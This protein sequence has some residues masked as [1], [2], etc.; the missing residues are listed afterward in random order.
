VDSAIARTV[1]VFPQVEGLR[2][3]VEQWLVSQGVSEVLDEYTKGL[4]GLDDLKIEFLAEALLR[5]TQFFVPE[6]AEATARE[7]VSRFLAEVRSEYLKIPELG[8]QLIANRV[9]EGSARSA[10][11]FDVLAAGLD[12]VKARLPVEA[13][14]SDAGAFDSQIDEARRHLEKYEYELAEHVCIRLRQRNWDGLNARQRF[15]TLSNL[16]AA[17]IAQGR[18]AEGARLLIEAKDWQ[19]DDDKALGNEARA[20]HLLGQNDRAFELATRA[21][22][23]FPNSPL[24]LTVWLNT[25]PSSYALKDLEDAV[26]AHLAED[27]EVVSALAER[28]LM[29][30]NNLKAEALARRA[31]SIKP[32]WSFPWAL[33]GG[34]VFRSILPDAPEDYA[35]LDS[36]ADEGRLREADEACTRAI[37][38]G[39]AEK[40][41]SVQA[42][43]LLIRAEVRRSLGDR[44]AGDEDVIAAWSPQPDDPTVLREYA[45]LKLQHGEK[46]DAIEKLRAAVR[47]E[48][49]DDLRMLLALSLSSTGRRDDRA[50][51]AQIYGSLATDPAQR[52]AGFRMHAIVAALDDFATDQ[53]WVEGRA[54]LARLPVGCLADTVIAALQ[55]KLELAAGNRE[56]ASEL[57]SEALTAI[58]ENTVPE[59]LRLA[60]TVLADLGRHRDALP[61]WQRLASPRY[62]GYDTSRLIDCALRVGQHDVFLTLC[63]Q[64]RS[65]GVY[66]RQLI[67]VEAGVREHY[68]VESAINLLQDYLSRFPEDCAARLH[69][70]AI[71]LQL[72][73]PELVATD[74]ASMPLPEDVPPENWKLIV[75]VMKSGGHLSEALRFAYSVLRR[76]FSAAEAHRAYLAAMLVTGP[77]PEIPRMDV[78]GPGTAVAFKEEGTTQEEWRIIEEEFEPDPGLQEIGPDHFI[79]VHLKGKRVGETFLLAEGSVTSTRGTIT[80]ILSKYV[81]RFQECSGNWQKRFPALP[82]IQSLRVLRVGPGGS[83]EIDLTQFFASLDRIAALQQKA[84]AAYCSQ[85]IPMHLLAQALSRTEF[86]QTIRLAVDDEV[87]VRC[88][89]GSAEERAEA[90]A[91]LK[92][93]SAVV[94]D[95][96]AIA[97]LSLLGALGELE[98]F[99]VEILISELTF[100]ELRNSLAVQTSED[101]EMGFLGKEGD[102]YVLEPAAPETLRVRREFLQSIV[103][104]VRS[105]CR[106]TGCPELAAVPPDRR[107]FLVKAIGEHGAQ[108]AVLASAPRRVLWTDDFCL[109]MIARHEFGARRVWTQVVLQERTEAGAV[110]P[111]TF[112]E[113]TAKL[114]GWR[115]Y[116]TSPSTPAL[117]RAGSL[118]EWN[119]ERRPLRSALELFSDSGIAARD[120][121]ALVVSFMV[122]Y[123]TEV[124]LPDVRNAL[125]VQILENLA[126]RGDGLGLIQALTSALPLVF[127]L[128]V[129]RAREFGQVIRAWIATKQAV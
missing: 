117:A 93:A 41:L 90:I 10:A 32:D 126:K 89:A 48:A 111:E 49:R 77:R 91:A 3:T 11:A 109:A 94:L 81:Y 95:L 70:S 101:G 13:S 51:A 62:L 85:P 55:G 7:I 17:N 127:D 71:G 103:D 66:D 61:L 88:C 33:L 59:D 122:H 38:L 40:Q 44:S 97:T 104:K 124:V 65:N 5:K 58:T 4:K 123:G 84:I 115:Y 19:P 45:R 53:R 106:I 8:L 82:D 18:A 75:L 107:E 14:V 98:R 60:A 113:A 116:F 114:I 27:V 30:R 26:P 16:A 15:R 28:A 128:N 96:T 112:F 46:Q 29:A 99:P 47:R 56:K 80:Q 73:R 57:A 64:L 21:R 69:L 25:A 83:Q 102:R 36:L 119:P 72:G 24:A 100:A 50:E 63:E 121:L 37:E 42:S 76:N 87:S 125:T 92:N 67:G 34:S 2:T 79:A 120:A 6:G 35:R 108:S 78:V 68:D 39:K 20:Y 110:T 54:L 1:E 86:E 9:E 23:R 12:E 74:P 129:L 118:A 52:P 22:E 105:G 31:T 43:V